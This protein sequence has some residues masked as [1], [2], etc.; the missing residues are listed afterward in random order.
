MSK[1]LRHLLTAPTVYIRDSDEAEMVE[2]SPHQY[3]SRKAVAVLCSPTLGSP[4][5]KSAAVPQ[6]RKPAMSLLDD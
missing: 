2:V 1:A 4:Q 5:A 6:R 3:L